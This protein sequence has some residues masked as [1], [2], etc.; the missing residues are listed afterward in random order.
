MGRSTAAAGARNQV[1]EN[2]RM[3]R[4]AFG[5]LFRVSK[6]TLGGGGLGMLW[7]RQLSTSVWR[8]FMLPW[9]RALICWTWRHVMATEKP[10]ALL[11]GVRRA[12]AGRCVYHQQMQSGN[13]GAGP[14]GWPTAPVL[15][16]EP[17]P[18]AA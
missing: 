2:L 3:E 4:H 6:L 7:G 16:D 12:P 13:S 8:P 10:S 9:L 1:P 14:G 15:R 11:R 5:S 17:R 18:A